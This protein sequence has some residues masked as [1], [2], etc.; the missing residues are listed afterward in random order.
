[1]TAIK[2]SDLP[3]VAIPDFNDEFAIVDISANE[4][5]KV[6]LGIIR[7]KPTYSWANLPNAALYQWQLVVISDN[8]NTPIAYSDGTNWRY[9]SDG[10]LVKME[11]IPPADIA[12]NLTAPTA[13]VDNP[14]SIPAVSLSLTTT[15][16]TGV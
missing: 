6:T 12:I 3:A 10:N 14:V 15:A 2:I 16:P 9:A 11:D 8:V 7:A 4:T 13:I 5:K 1:M